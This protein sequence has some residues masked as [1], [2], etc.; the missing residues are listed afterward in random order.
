MRFVILVLPLALLTAC[1][2]GSKTPV[3]PPTPRDSVVPRDSLRPVYDSL[4]H[5]IA[6][7]DSVAR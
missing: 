1:P 2:S 4:G 7:P 3:P 5:I 6:S